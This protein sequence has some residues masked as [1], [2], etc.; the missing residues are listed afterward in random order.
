MTPPTFRDR[1]IFGKFN[2]SSENF[3][4]FAVDKNK[5]FQIL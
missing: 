4:T 5:K 3:I 1:R 2:V